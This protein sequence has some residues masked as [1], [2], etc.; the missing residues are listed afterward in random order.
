MMA[1]IMRPARH[2]SSSHPTLLTAW[3]DTLY[4]VANDGHHGRELWR[5]DGSTDGTTRLTDLNVGKSDANIVELI[6]D[7]NALFIS[8]KSEDDVIEFL[9]T[10]DGG[11]TFST[12]L[13]QDWPAPRTPNPAPFFGRATAKHGMELWRRD[14]TGESFAF[15]CFPGPPGSYPSGFTPFGARW[16]FRASAVEAGPILWVTDER[17]HQVQPLLVSGL[18]AEKPR[19]ITVFGAGVAYV[20]TSDRGLNLLTYLTPNKIHQDVLRMP[21]QTFA[22]TQLVATSSTLFFVYEDP[23]YGRELWKSHGK[24]GDA[25]RVADVNASAR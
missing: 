9:A 14:A 23:L 20:H 13:A 11:A 6:A 22:P 25:Q 10:T 21:S 4:F 5:S 3:K 15:D 8:R 19:E 24:S 17:A 18:T 12:V 7:E 2:T 16:I 1:D